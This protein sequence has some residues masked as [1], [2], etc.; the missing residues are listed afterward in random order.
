MRGKES[1]VLPCFSFFSFVFSLCR[2]QAEEQRGEAS[3]AG[4]GQEAVKIPCIY[5]MIAKRSKAVR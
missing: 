3:S 1:F 2:L 5:A 4:Q